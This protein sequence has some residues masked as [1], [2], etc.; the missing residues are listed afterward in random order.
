MCNIDRIQNCCRIIRI[1]VADEFCFHFEFVVFLCPVFKCKIH[2]T[3]TKVTSADTDLNNR[4]KLFSRS[5]RDFPIVNL[6]CEFCDTLLL[7]LVESTLVHAICDNCITQLT[8]GHMMQDQTFFSSIDD[9]ATVKSFKF[10]CQ[11]RF[12]SQF[13]QCVKYSII[14]LLCCI[15]VNKSLCHRHTVFF[16]AL[17]A[18]LSGH[19]L[20]KIHTGCLFQLLI[21]SKSIQVIPGNHI[22]IPPS[23]HYTDF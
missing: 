12:I 19:C 9:F 6:V 7:L 15:V 3:R 8:T 22:L 10:L 14:Y 17:C 20:R 21:G 13:L 1:Y 2:C 23:I 11:L 18:F 4:G 16:N 5:I